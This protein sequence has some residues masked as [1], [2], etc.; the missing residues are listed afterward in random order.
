M[1]QENTAAEA[2]EFLMNWSDEASDSEASQVS[3][4]PE[5]EQHFLD[6]VDPD[7]EM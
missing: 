4:D 7:L 6:G 5:D 2:A 3:E 1:A